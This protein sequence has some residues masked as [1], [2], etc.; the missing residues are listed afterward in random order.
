MV[1]TFRELQDLD[2]LV[3][4]LYARVPTVK[5]TKFGYAY[6][7]FVEKNYIPTLKDFQEEIATV[8]VEFALEDDKTKEILIDRANPRGYKYSKAG[9]KQVMFEEKKVMDKW[10]TFEIEIKPFISSYVPVE[11]NEE[12]IES[13][14]GL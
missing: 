14:K 9:T 12:E 2:Q 11:L 10:D 13:L 5:D 8:R 3:G 6:K 1:K 7:R 4:G